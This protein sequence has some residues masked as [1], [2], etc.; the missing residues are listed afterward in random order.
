MIDQS[1]K[2]WNY[3]LRFWLFRV[4]HQW[5][6]NY[7]LYNSVQSIIEVLLELY[8]QD[9]RVNIAT[10]MHNI[11]KS[12]CNE[13]ESHVCFSTDCCS[14]EVVILDNSQSHQSDMIELGCFGWLV[15]LW[16]WQIIIAVHNDCVADDKLSLSNS[17]LPWLYLQWAVTGDG[18]SKLL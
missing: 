8:D 16:L 7:L 17:D 6:S 2:T 4:Y 5:S 9:K 1:D 12:I 11:N 3:I 13:C 18:Y 15:L 10:W 14:S